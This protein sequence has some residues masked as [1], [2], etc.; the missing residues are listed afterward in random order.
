[1]FDIAKITG[2]AFGNINRIA[3]IDVSDIV[4]GA[5][6]TP[7]E[8]DY[9][10]E[11]YSMARSINTALTM[12]YADHD[13]YPALI[14]ALVTGDYIDSVTMPDTGKYS[15]QRHSEDL[16]AAWW[17]GENRVVGGVTGRYTGDTDTVTPVF[18][19]PSELVEWMNGF[20]E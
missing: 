18:R 9:A 5:L 7:S 19:T 20:S 4:F 2:V 12:Y 11:A 16:F 10:S 15:Y 8:P 6:L 1:M 14:D 3:K 17:E 13:E